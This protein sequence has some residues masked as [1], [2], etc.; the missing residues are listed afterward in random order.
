MSLL[1]NAVVR[2]A[3]IRR[4]RSIDMRRAVLESIVQTQI[5]FW[6]WVLGW[7]LGPAQLSNPEILQGAVLALAIGVVTSWLGLRQYLERQALRRFRGR[8]G[9]R[10]RRL[11]VFEDHL[12]LDDEIVVRSEVSDYAAEEGGF[13][14][15]YEPSDG[16][17]KR[18]RNFNCETK[19]IQWLERYFT[20]SVET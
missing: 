20:P 11:V 6:A 13:S 18:R 17:H 1:S 9:G 14:L 8:E 3:E 12:W 16:G 7:F 19:S 4:F 15:E 2:A 5:L 10:R